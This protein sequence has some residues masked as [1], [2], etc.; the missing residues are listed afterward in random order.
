MAASRKSAERQAYYAGPGNRFW[1]TLFEIGLTPFELRPADFGRL[2][3]FGIGL[4]DVNKVES[5][6][7]RQLSPD[8]HDPDRVIGKTTRFGP[9]ILAF[10]GKGAARLVLGEATGY[11][12]A[13]RQI[14][15]TKIFVLPS[16]SGAARGYWSIE[17]WRALARAAG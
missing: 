12:L 7:D 16:T 1:A 5:G 17:P 9:G 2:P 3:E 10:N 11:G 8:R 6:T 15:H 13:S 14:G 4:T